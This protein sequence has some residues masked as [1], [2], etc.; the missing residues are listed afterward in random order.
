MV[1][2]LGGDCEGTGEVTLLS[3][4]TTGY[5]QL[6]ISISYS[7]CSDRTSFLLLLDIQLYIL[8]I[9]PL[10]PF[11]I[12]TF[13]SARIEFLFFIYLSQYTIV[14]KSSQILFSCP[15]TTGCFRGTFIYLIFL[16][17]KQLLV[18][19]IF[20]FSKKQCTGLILMLKTTCVCMEDFSDS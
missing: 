2:P 3:T 8:Q 12:V 18:C 4:Y 17:D 19:Y 1:A 10:Q 16:H 6:F 5:V 15:D 14:F 20:L 11:F 9:Q 13:Q 7:T